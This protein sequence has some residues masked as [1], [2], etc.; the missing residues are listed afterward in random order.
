MIQR[1]YRVLISGAGVAGLS[2]ANALHRMGHSVR[3][4]ERHDDLQPLGAGLILWSNAINALRELGLEQAVLK[5]GHHLT[6][7]AI[8]D[9]DGTTLGRTNAATIGSRV[10]APTLAVH[11]ADLLPLILEQLPPDVLITNHHLTGF[12]Q[13][14]GNV[15]AYFADGSREEGDVLIGADGIWS[16]IRAQIH[17]NQPARY[18]GYTAWRAVTENPQVG[19]TTR[20]TESWGNGLRFGWVPMSDNRVYWFAVKNAPEGESMSERGHRD[21]LLSR[22]GDW[23]DPIRETISSTPESAILRH[24]IYDRPPISHWGRGNVTLAGDAAHPMTPN[25]GQGAA[26]AIEDAVVLADCL[27]RY[28]TI[29]G[30]LRAYEAVRSPRTRM[31]TNISRR[32]GM[33]AQVESHY[34]TL[35][36]NLIARSIPDAVSVRQISPIVDWIPPDLKGSSI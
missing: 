15:K 11:R 33:T 30:A 12:E 34:G 3:V 18:A 6:D 22:F 29:E 13:S 10:G 25:T 1:K 16:A 24:D 21:E 8:L 2:A 14:S 19:S 4:F 7:L 23:H 32:I 20:S 36:R 9:R 26:Q 31:I 17:G 5:I 28:R 27:K 35:A